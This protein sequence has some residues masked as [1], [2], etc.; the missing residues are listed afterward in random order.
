MTPGGTLQPSALA[1]T[2]TPEALFLS[3]FD[4]ET[5]YPENVR[6]AGVCGFFGVVG[7]AVCLSCFFFRPS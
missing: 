5:V 6:T 2:L 3:G 1:G 7:D 4:P